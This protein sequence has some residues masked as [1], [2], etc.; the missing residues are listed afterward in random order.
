MFMLDFVDWV[1]SKQGK[2]VFFLFSCFPLLVL[3]LLALLYMSCVL[4]CA[5]LLCTINAFL[6]LPVK[7]LKFTVKRFLLLKEM[8]QLLI[9]S[10]FIRILN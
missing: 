6:C 1:Q 2:G 8:Y 7:K 9:M 10:F 5:L 4:Q 3:Y